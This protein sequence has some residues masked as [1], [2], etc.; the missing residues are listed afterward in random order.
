MDLQLGGTSS[1]KERNDLTNTNEEINKLNEIDERED[2]DSMNY[3][4]VTGLG[5]SN[6][7]SINFALTGTLNGLSL[8]SQKVASLNQGQLKELEYD[9]KID[10][11]NQIIL[12]LQAKVKQLEAA[13]Q[14]GEDGFDEEAA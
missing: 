3:S 13:K 1:F 5:R 10:E 8:L 11:M 14:D 12:D 6:A 7:S 2:E 9:N 4:E